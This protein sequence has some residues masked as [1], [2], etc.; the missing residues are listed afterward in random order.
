MYCCG[1]FLPIM[2]ALHEIGV[3][4]LNIAQPNV[5]DIAEVGRRLRGRQCLMM[6]ISYQTLPQ[7]HRLL[8]GGLHP[9]RGD[10]RRADR[11]VSGHQRPRH[12]AR[13]AH[14]DGHVRPLRREFGDRLGFHGGIDMQHLLP[15]ASPADVEAEAR[16]Y[17]ETLGRG[18]GY[19]LAPAHLFQPDVPPE[20]ILA[21]YRAVK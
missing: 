2:E 10:H 11:P 9:R 12:P 3:D 4:V 8:P 18:G 13:A 19:V 17:C 14:F 7:V 16:R 20:N 5:N 15:Q 21:V 6:A 1:E